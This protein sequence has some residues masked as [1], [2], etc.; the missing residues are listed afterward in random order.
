MQGRISEPGVAWIFEVAQRIIT[1]QGSV[2]K[3]DNGNVWEGDL[4]AGAKQKSRESLTLASIVKLLVHV[5]R[6]FSTVSNAGCCCYSAI[7]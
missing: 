4:T 1:R 7:Q 2:D 5:E 3:L 6:R